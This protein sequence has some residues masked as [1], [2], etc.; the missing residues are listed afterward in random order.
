M[1]NKAKL[2]QA[3][4]GTAI[5][6]G[7]VGEV[8]NATGV[9]DIEQ[10]TPTSNTYYDLGGS[11]PLT[12]GT[13][14]IV[15]RAWVFGVTPGSI[16]GEVTPIIIGA[17]RTSANVLLDDCFVACGAVNGVTFSGA[18]HISRVVTISSSTTYKASGKWISNSGTATL[19]KIAM[20]VATSNRGAFYAVRIA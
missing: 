18:L 12:A 20:Q 4:D 6:S 7:F 13:W 5:P 10:A 15:L 14:K 16:S 2:Q 8:V 9:T 19:G 1:A 17:L 11:L 3:G